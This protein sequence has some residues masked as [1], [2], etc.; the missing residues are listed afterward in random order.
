[1]DAVVDRFQLGGLVDHMLRGGD[2]AAVM[3]PGGKAQG[4]PVVFRHPKGCERALVSAAGGFRQP[5]G[6][7]GHPGAM[8]AGVG[9]FGV[10]R[11][12]HQGDQGIEEVFL[13]LNQIR[14]LQGDGGI[15]CQGLTEGDPFRFRWLGEMERQLAFVIT[16]PAAQR[17]RDRLQWLLRLEAT[18]VEDAFGVVV[19]L[20][21]DPDPGEHGSLGGAAGDGAFH[22]QLEQG[23]DVLFLRQGCGGGQKPLDRLAHQ[24][25][26]GVEFVDLGN[27]RPGRRSGAEIKATDRLGLPA[28]GLQRSGHRP[29]Q[30]PDQGQRRNH[31]GHRDPLRLANGGH[32][33][34]VDI[35]RRNGQHEQ[36]GLLLKADSRQLRDAQQPVSAA[37]G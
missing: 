20:V 15:A 36:G 12:G 7:L 33:R 2:L 22:Q 30:P 13:G 4:F 14:V 29:G 31:D 8:G 25:Q 6:E 24:R 1:M 34:G 10:D 18:G 35:S 26:G 5:L 28:E 9:T 21:C 27:D 3:Q 16:I 32:R 19:L 23:V 37:D 11:T 17:D